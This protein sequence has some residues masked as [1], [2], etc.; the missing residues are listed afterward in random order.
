[1]DST[2]GQLVQGNNT[3]VGQVCREATAHAALVA[4]T[5]ARPGQFMGREWRNRQLMVIGATGHV[6]H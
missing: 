2:M 5:V 6:G 4:M 1:M 3:T